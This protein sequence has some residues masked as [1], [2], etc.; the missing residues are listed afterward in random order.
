M[1]IRAEHCSKVLTLVD[2]RVDLLHNRYVT[3]CV[4]REVRDLMEF[5]IVSKGDL[6]QG[7]IELYYSL[8]GNVQFKTSIFLCVR[9]EFYS[10]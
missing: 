4:W 3:K 9:V 1:V 8:L 2:T 7:V 10:K 6:R 5:F